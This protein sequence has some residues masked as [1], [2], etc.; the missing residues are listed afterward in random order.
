MCQVH[1][2]AAR[3][4]AAAL[5]ESAM[6]RKLKVS[7]LE[8]ALL[9][10][11]EIQCDGETD[12]LSLV[13]T[14]LNRDEVRSARTSAGPAL[15]VETFATALAHLAELGMLQ[16]RHPRASDWWA[17]DAGAAAWDQR[18]HEAEIASLIRSHLNVDAETG[19]FCVR[20]DYIFGPGNGRAIEILRTSR[21]Q[22]LR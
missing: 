2:P 12:P 22:D 4:R 9:N 10:A 11:L 13:I 14:L 15:T 5:E 21:S 16:V 1:P 8:G 20:N 3:S 19:E 7:T 6:P 17:P 18:I